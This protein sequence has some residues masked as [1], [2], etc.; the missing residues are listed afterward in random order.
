[1]V[2]PSTI[3]NNPHWSQNENAIAGLVTESNIWELNS[4]IGSSQPNSDFAGATLGD[5]ST[6]L[7]DS[8]QSP[9]EPLGEKVAVPAIDEVILFGKTQRG[10]P[11]AF[12]PENN[13]SAIGNREIGTPGYKDELTGMEVLPNSLFNTASEPVPNSGAMLPEQNYAIAVPPEADKLT[14]SPYV[15]GVTPIP[16]ITSSSLEPGSNLITARD[17]GYL[18]GTQIFSEFVGNFDPSDI[19]RF[20]LRTTEDLSLFL[21]GLNAGADVRLIQDRNHNSTVEYGEIIAQSVSYN[22]TPQSITLSNLNPGSYFVEINQ[23]IGNTNYNL[24]MSSVPASGYNSN[25][26]YGL[27]DASAAVAR[28]AGYSTPFPSAAPVGGS[29]WT[30]DMVNAPAVWNRGYTGNGVVVAVIDSGVDYTHPD[31]DGNIWVNTDEIPGNG[32]DDDR[33]GYVDDVRGWDF[34]FNDSDPMDV[35]GHGT[36][37]AGAIAAERDGAGITGVA[38]NAKIMPVKVG[39]ASPLVR[40]NDIAAGIRYAVDNGADVINLSFGSNFP[41]FERDTAIS[42][43]ISRG[44]VVVMAAGNEGAS[45]PSFPAR[46]SDV[47]GIAVG[48]V[49]GNGTMDRSSSRAGSTP[50]DYVVAPGANVYSTIPNSSY[51]TSSGTSIAAPHVAGV[52]ALVLS[53]NPNLVASQVET[54]IATSANPYQVRV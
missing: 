47:W 52:A 28:A 43:A 49:D 9:E 54:L 44:V 13:D 41:S 7:F 10:L 42:Y 12:L 39:N 37:V 48:S 21:N 1:M 33:N 19:Y 26:G 20:S 16:T 50:L 30:R 23:F 4:G 24:T 22:N 36:H 45:Q 3:N 5:R 38:P 34:A 31:L 40:H 46:Y 2:D 15:P 51:R 32:I 11:M 17:L 8:N 25:Y 6:T 29:D 14:N 27:V 18:N 35:L 53:A